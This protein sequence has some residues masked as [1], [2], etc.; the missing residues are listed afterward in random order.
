MTAEKEALRRNERIAY[1]KMETARYVYKQAQHQNSSALI[2]W[3]LEQAK[4]AQLEWAAAYKL[5]YPN[6]RKDT[7]WTRP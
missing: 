2:A 5:A 7:R 1:G 6:G 4:Q 3:A